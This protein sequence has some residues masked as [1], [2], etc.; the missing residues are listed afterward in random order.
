LVHDEQAGTSNIARS[1]YCRCL[2]VLPQEKTGEEPILMWLFQR[3]EAAAVCM[4]SKESA[5]LVK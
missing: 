1:P 5:T 2:I 4:P 3:Q